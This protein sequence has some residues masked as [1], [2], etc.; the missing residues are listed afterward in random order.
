MEPDT[1][2]L[3]HLGI[4]ASSFVM[5]NES[6]ENTLYN[7]AQVANISQ[8]VGLS[9]LQTQSLT[10]ARR[11]RTKQP[12]KRVAEEIIGSCFPVL[13][14]SDNDVLKFESLVLLHDMVSQVTGYY[15]TCKQVFLP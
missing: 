8:L 15:F 10:L 6:T 12:G 14:H 4:V 7:M 5:M 3:W 9:L 1:R 11:H 2:P 13:Q